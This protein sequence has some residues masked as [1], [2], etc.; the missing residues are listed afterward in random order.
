HDR[1]LGGGVGGGSAQRT[2][3][4]CG[5]TVDDRAA[6][7]PQVRQGGTGH[8][9]GAQEVHG[10]HLFPLVRRDLVQLPAGIDPGGVDHR[11]DPPVFFHCAGDSPFDLLAVADVDVFEGHR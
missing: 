2:Q 5:G 11:V 1:E 10:D 6:V 7:G 4:E 3:T 8:R 9:H